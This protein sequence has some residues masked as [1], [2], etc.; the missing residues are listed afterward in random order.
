[1]AEKLLNLIPTDLGRPISDIKP[2]IQC[3]DLE[4][5][6]TRVID[7]VT[8]VEQEVRDRNGNWYTMRI[9][10]YK[11]TENRIDGAVVALFESD[12]AHTRE[13]EA[14]DRTTDLRATLAMV[15]EPVAVLDEGLRVQ[16]TTR[17]F[18]ELLGL[19]CPE[20][21]GKNLY[22]VTAG[23][24]DREDLRLLL[25][26]ELPRHG[27]VE[28]YRIGRVGADAGALGLT[29]AARAMEPSAGGGRLHILVVSSSEEDS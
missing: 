13:K 15:H 21:D 27:M 12:T 19:T 6:I 26:Q 24:W 3:P 23:R 8:I 18:C 14:M 2:N 29:V 7:T 4:E 25:E 22:E 1:M 16:T 5:L 11:N 9:R 20:V 28:Q 10:P 17:E